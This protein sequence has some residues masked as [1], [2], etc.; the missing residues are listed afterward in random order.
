M[1]AGIDATEMYKGACGLVMHRAKV[2]IDSRGMA[3]IHL[4]ETDNKMYGQAG[5]C[6]N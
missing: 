3:V 6:I 2:C 5:M 1:S 4:S